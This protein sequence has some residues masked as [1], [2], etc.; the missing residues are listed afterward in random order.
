MNIVVGTRVNCV[1]HWTGRGIV[2]AVHGE[3][4]GTATFDVVF[5]NGEISRGLSENVIRGV[6][7]SILS[8]I[9]TDAEIA[10]ALAHAE[11]IATDRKQTDEDSARRIADE[12][13]RLRTDP[14]YRNLVQGDDHHSGKI[15]I[16]NIRTEL[17]AAFPRV[18][19]SVRNP[20]HGT[21]IIAWTDGPTEARV[22]AI[23]DKYAAFTF[24]PGGTF[25]DRDM[26]QVNRDH[27][28]IQVFGA[29]DY[30]FTSR[31]H[32]DAHMARA[33]DALFASHAGLEGIER[34]TP[35]T[36]FGVRVPVP[37]EDWDLAV[38]I[39]SK[40]AELEGEERRADETQP[41]MGN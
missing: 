22:N 16:Q 14:A 26:D 31:I 10:G 17:K 15:A 39:R 13:D 28:W 25:K 40:A 34:P 5:E 8:E 1:L 41:G 6:Q 4:P 3:Q 18:R 38:L 21:I 35:E 7:W 12:V 36:A 30:I 37:G 11:Q 9:A 32:S 23:S 2:S 20:R 27:A 24:H 33:I 29:A 19:F